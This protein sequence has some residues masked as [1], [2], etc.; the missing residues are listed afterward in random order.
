MPTPDYYQILGV[1]PD[2]NLKTI[3]TAYRKMA[4][5]YHPDR[6]TEQSSEER[7]KQINEA[8]AVLSDSKKRAAYDRKRKQVIVTIDLFHLFTRLMS[9][10]IRS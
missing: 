3:K 1:A 8:Y 6:Q 2:A 5:Q 4:Q 7:M 10:F 9:R